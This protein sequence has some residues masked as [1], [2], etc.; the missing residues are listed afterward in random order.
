MGYNHKSNG[1]RLFILCYDLRFAKVS[2]R[3][4]EIQRREE[5]PVQ[6]AAAGFKFFQRHGI[7]TAE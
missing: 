7:W 6:L 2:I 1:D 3:R 4:N 5:W